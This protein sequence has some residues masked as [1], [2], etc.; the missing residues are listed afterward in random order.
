MAEISEQEIEQ[1]VRTC[2]DPKPEKRMEAAKA[3]E[4]HIKNPNALFAII[5]LTHDRDSRVRQ[6]A[7]EMMDNAKA[8]YRSETVKKLDESLFKSLEEAQKQEQEVREKLEKVEDAIL[9]EGDVKKAFNLLKDFSVDEMDEESIPEGEQLSEDDAVNLLEGI[10]SLDDLTEI[11]IRKL[12]SFHTSV[13]KSAIYRYI[14]N[15]IQ[16]KGAGKKE[17]TREKKRMVDDYKRKVSLAFD[18]AWYNIKRQ[19]LRYQIAALKDGMKRIDVE[20]VIVTDISEKSIKKGRRFVHCMRIVVQD[21]SGSIPA[22]IEKNRGEGIKLE[23]NLDLE[24]I[25]VQ[26]LE[27]ELAINVLPSSRIIIKR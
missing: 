24:K 12:D 7:R 18:V 26:M 25:S 13:E 9:T 16:T 21:Q 14:Y 3:L 17:I 19:E 20:S 8:T 15:F 1:W 4:K 27:N 11:Q 23:D 5:E 6:L 22:Y 2:F 10:K